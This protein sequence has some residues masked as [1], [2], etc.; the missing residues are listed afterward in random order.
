MNVVVI[1]LGIGNLMSVIRALE[2]YGAKVV[3]TSDSQTILNSSHVILPGDGAFNFAMEQIKKRNLLE[4]LK[5]FKNSQSNLLGICIGMQILFDQSSEFGITEGLGLIPGKVIPIPKKSK[6]GLKLTIPHI[7]W[8]SLN[9]TENFK[10]WNNTLLEDNKVM[11]EMYFIHSYMAVPS[12]SSSRVADCI[13][14][15]HK[16]AAVVIKNNIVG[17]QFH[18]EKS[19]KLGLK[20]LKKF[21]D[22]K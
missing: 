18:P 13:Y 7:G 8:N 21:I 22:K 17:C 5:S 1:D 2:Y 9:Q 20:I 11:D 15:G 3:V 6:E 12:N 19:G 10:D 16:L 4:T 14:G